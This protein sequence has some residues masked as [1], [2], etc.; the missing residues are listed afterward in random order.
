MKG[1]KR[2]KVYTMSDS[3]DDIDAHDDRFEGFNLDPTD[4]FIDAAVR[5]NDE[6]V[7]DILSES[8][9][10]HSAVLAARVYERKN[11]TTYGT[12]GDAHRN[13]SYD[14]EKTY[15]LALI[16]EVNKDDSPEMYADMRAVDD[17]MTA[18]Q[19]RAKV[20]AK[21]TEVE[22]KKAELAALEDELNKME[23]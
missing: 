11:H 10:S 20:E 2:R 1:R 19:Q 18:D 12:I 21:W 14:D 15:H 17:E 7:H 3:W 8:V 23:N 22:Q 16:V 4:L 13:K 5:L 9:E 6:R